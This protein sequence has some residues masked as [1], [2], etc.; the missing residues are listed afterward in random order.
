MDFDLGMGRFSLMAL[1]LAIDGRLVLMPES[2]RHCEV[3][4]L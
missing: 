3:P 1:E 2:S 4:A